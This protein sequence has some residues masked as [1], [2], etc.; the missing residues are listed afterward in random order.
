MGFTEDTD[1]SFRSRDCAFEMLIPCAPAMLSILISFS[2]PQPPAIAHS[3]NTTHHHLTSMDHP[4]TDQWAFP[5][6]WFK[7]IKSASRVNLGLFF[8]FCLLAYIY[9]MQSVGFVLNND[10]EIKCMKKNRLC[11]MYLIV[12][13]I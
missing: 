3:W 5:V 12:C 13:Y 4:L 1:R 9:C 10:I 6:L 7:M 11:Y 2:Y 8:S